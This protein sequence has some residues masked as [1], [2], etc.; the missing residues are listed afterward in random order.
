MSG[1][2]SNKHWRSTTGPASPYPFRVKRKM[3]NPV[4][5]IP[6]SGVDTV[7]I[8]PNGDPGRTGSG[9]HFLLVSRM[10]WSKGIRELIQAAEAVQEKHP[11]S[12]FTMIGGYS[13][14]GAK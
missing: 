10:L 13:G 4:F 7:V 5:I 6:G 14:G 2:S 12:R 3:G 9:L 11:R 1:S 8:R